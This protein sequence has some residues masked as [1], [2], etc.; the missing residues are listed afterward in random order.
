MQHDK[1][2]SVGL[3]H[4]I[5][6]KHKISRRLTHYEQGNTAIFVFENKYLLVGTALIVVSSILSAYMFWGNLASLHFL[7]P[8]T[9]ME[10]FLVVLAGL[11]AALSFK[12]NLFFVVGKLTGRLCFEVSDKLYIYYRVASINLRVQSWPLTKIV[13]AELCHRD[14]GKTYGVGPIPEPGQFFVR[15]RFRNTTHMLT[16]W[17]DEAEA[18]AIVASINARLL[19]N[20]EAA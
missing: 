4:M 19:T 11:L 18:K 16:D 17:I 8:E 7:A 12:K 20:L 13:R 6:F 1:S 5:G 3:I 10:L 14:D 9:L 2:W 15:L